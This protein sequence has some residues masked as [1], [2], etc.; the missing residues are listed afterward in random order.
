MVEIFVTDITSPEIADLIF[1]HLQSL[2]P[3]ARVVFDL[4]DCDKILKI[5]NSEIDAEGIIHLVA[6]HGYQCQILE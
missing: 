2:W 5:E 1:E 3:D 4:E 6:K